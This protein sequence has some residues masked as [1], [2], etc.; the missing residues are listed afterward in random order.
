MSGFV[1][2]ATCWECK[3]GHCTDEWHSWAD[4]DDSAHA[5]AHGNPDPSSE[6]CNCT[7]QTGV[8]ACRPLDDAIDAFRGES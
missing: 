3:F 2:L 4:E 8:S 5:L 6:Q 1:C 7:C